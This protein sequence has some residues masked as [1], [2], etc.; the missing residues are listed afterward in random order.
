MTETTTASAPVETVEQP[1]Q[2][3]LKRFAAAFA[4][5]VRTTAAAIK[6]ALVRNVGDNESPA[7]DAEGHF[8]KALR[9]ALAVPK[10][11]G[12]GLLYVAKMAVSLVL[13]LAYGYYLLLLGVVSVVTF[14]ALMAIIVVFKIAQGIVLA[15]RTPYLLVRGD[16][17]LV[18]DWAGYAALW[19]PRYFFYSTIS[20][21]YFAKRMEQEKMEDQLWS[22][23]VKVAQDMAA[24]NGSV[25]DPEHPVFAQKPAHET[26][27]TVHDGHQSPTKG[28]ATPKQRK[29]RPARMPKAAFA[30]AEA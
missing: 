25:M 23:A 21:V 26:V 6:A 8:R 20:Q 30:G 5:K 3:M 19:T 1:Q 7:T 14:V 11:I 4:A 22:E 16:D 9:Y 17:C 15:V 29:R 2:G 12:L 27:L 18:T 24:S 13:L 28:H 10:W